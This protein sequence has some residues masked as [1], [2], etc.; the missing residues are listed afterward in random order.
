M[1][2]QHVEVQAPV[3]R[4]AELAWVLDTVLRGRLGLSYTLAPASDGLVTLSAPGGRVQWADVFLAQAH[5]GWLRARPPVA[6][7]AAARIGPHGV[8]C[9]F[10]DGCHEDDGHTLRLPLDLSGSI[11]FMLSRYEEALPDAERDRHGRSPASASLAGRAGLLQRPLVDEWV[12]LLAWALQRAGAAVRPPPAPRR[13][14]TCDVDLAYSPGI[15]RPWAATRQAA[16]HLLKERSP[17][18]AWRAALNPW[19]RLVGVDGLD[20]YDNFDWMMSANEALGQRL[21]FFFLCPRQATHYEGFYAIEDARLRRLVARILERGHQVGLHASYA[22][23]DD[24][25]LLPQEVARLRAVAGGDALP[26]VNRQHFLRW[27]AERTPADLEAAGIT[28]DTSLAHADVAGFRCGTSHPFALFDLRGGRAT[29]VVEQPLV[30][31]EGTLFGTQYMNLG[32]G[33]RALECVQALQRA[34]ARFGGCFTL[35]WHN[36]GLRAAA[37]RALYRQAIAPPAAGEV[38]A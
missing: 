34:C 32:Q 33:E 14:I 19:A 12:A 36:T 15:D 18:L 5:E 35:L 23:V 38:A 8:A 21:A 4:R 37:A 13:W 26:V 16:A 20:P 22:S 17:A 28:L 31:M 6:A 10:G 2:P 9:L 7:P 1:N 27:R 3:Q 11:F 24:P 29:R 30:L 25:T